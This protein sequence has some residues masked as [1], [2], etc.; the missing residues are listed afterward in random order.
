MYTKLSEKIDGVEQ[1]LDAK[2]DAT[3]ARGFGW[4]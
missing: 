2:M 4:I 3:M 1:R